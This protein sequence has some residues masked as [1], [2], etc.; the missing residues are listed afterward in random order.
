TDR[1][2]GS[3]V[4][5]STVVIQGGNQIVVSIPGTTDTDLVALGKAAVL[6]LRG[7]VM[8]P[9]AVACLPLKITPGSTGTPTTSSSP[10]TSAS[11]SP[12][13]SSSPSSSTSKSTKDQS[14]RKLDVPAAA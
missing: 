7:A 2:N 1:V 13:A 5:Q 6:S 4:T 12:P 8:P 11:S 9:Q 3:G 14:L 10:S